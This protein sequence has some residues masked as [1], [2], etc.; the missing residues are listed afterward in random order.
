MVSMMSSDWDDFARRWTKRRVIRERKRALALCTIHTL[1]G[2]E[3]GPAYGW[4][5]TAFGL[6]AA[7]S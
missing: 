1:A 5:L 3:F 4:R 6:P 7:D 2:D